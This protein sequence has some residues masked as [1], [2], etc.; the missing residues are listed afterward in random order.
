M[1]TELL[2][3][4]REIGVGV[5]ETLKKQEALEKKQEAIEVR[6]SDIEKWAPRKTGL[7][8]VTLPGLADEKKPFS[9]AKA[10]AGAAYQSKGQDIWDSIDAGFEREVLQ[11]A[12]KKSIDTGTGGS[13]GGLVVPQE[14][15]NQIIPL[16]RAKTAVIKAG[17]TVLEGLSG[18]P[19]A[20]PKQTGAG[21]AYWLGQ[22]A[23]IPTGDATFGQVQMTP[24]VMAARVQYSN[25]LNI[26][27]N[28][29]IEE[30]IR[31]D[32]A[33][34]AALELDRVALRG[35]GSSNQPLGIVNIAGIQ[36]LPIGTNGGTYTFDVASQALALLDSANALGEK[37][38]FVTHPKVSWKMRRERIPQ[39]SGDAG[40]AYVTLPIISDAKLNEMLG[41]PMFTTT[42][43]P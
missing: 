19:V 21:Q 6:L 40:G 31:N 18:S 41:Y 2:E 10:F 35:S 27:S 13:G 33:R 15:T 22:N 20:I 12:T 34:I 30:L 29:S 4:V 37:V 39:F 43:L 7:G 16:L 14:Y 26:L 1:G 32:F 36:T 24:H 23:S 38:G 25:L 5:K 17:A 8:G 11:Q 3:Q 28:P 42:Q 9:F